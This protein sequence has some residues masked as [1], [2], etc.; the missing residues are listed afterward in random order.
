MTEQLKIRFLIIFYHST[1]KFNNLIMI[2]LES[3]NESLNK[4]IDIAKL[5]NVR[6]VFMMNL[7]QVI[8]I[9]DSITIDYLRMRYLSNQFK[10]YK[11]KEFLDFTYYNNNNQIIL[12][13]SIK[14]HIKN[15]YNIIIDT[16]IYK[17]K[18]II[19]YISTHPNKLILDVRDDLFDSESEIK[20]NYRIIEYYKDTNNIN[21]FLD[22][23]KVKEIWNNICFNIDVVLNNEFSNKIII[24]LGYYIISIKI[25]NIDDKFELLHMITNA[26]I[27]I[28]S[29]CNIEF[30]LNQCLFLDEQY[31]KIHNELSNKTI[32]IVNE[33]F[34]E[35]ITGNIIYI[36]YD[37]AIIM[38]KNE[39]LECNRFDK[40]INNAEIILITI[41]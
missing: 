11:F 6:S 29:R 28:K 2:K 1:F 25:N 8:E 19:R 33:R 22:N 30:K 35:L 36:E 16:Y 12:S 10:D 9:T 41:N 23:H 14:E 13:R 5:Y 32:M 15:V 37:I 39:L 24:L 3:E 31:D 26:N 38:Y 7:F 18:Y 20:T 17:K 40:W 34:W 4:L 27:W 21:K